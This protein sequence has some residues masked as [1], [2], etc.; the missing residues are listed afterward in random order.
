MKLFGDLQFR[1]AWNEAL[2]EERLLYT[3]HLGDLPEKERGHVDSRRQMRVSRNSR[4]SS[5]LKSPISLLKLFQ[6]K[7]LKGIVGYN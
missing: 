4:H 2:P 7:L 3:G 1:H 5:R 6:W